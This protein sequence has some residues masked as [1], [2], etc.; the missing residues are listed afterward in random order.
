MT[1]VFYMSARVV[2][3]LLWLVYTAVICM[4]WCGVLFV[5][6]SG[7][8][9]CSCITSLGIRLCQVLVISQQQLV[10]MCCKISITPDLHP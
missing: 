9:A 2:S 6:T 1:L 8:F 7:A 3:S 10:F 5:V 4:Y